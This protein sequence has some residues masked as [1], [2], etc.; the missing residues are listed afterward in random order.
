[1]LWAEA[2]DPVAAR[3]ARGAREAQ[4][5]GQLVRAYLLYQA[6]A[7]RDP[8][9]STYRANCDALAPAA[10]LLTKADIQNADVSAEIKA[11][12][13]EPVGGEPPVEL[14]SLSVW[15]HDESLQPLPHLLAKTE[16]PASFDIR[17]DEKSLFQQ[18]AATYGIRPIFDPQLDVRNDIRFQ[19][20]KAEFRTVMEALTA[21]THTFIFPISQH[22]FFVARDTELKRNELEPNI[23]LTFPL[24]NAL[25]QKD[26]LE[27]A[28]AVR[29]VLNLRAV[30]WDSANRTVM[31][32][33][34]YTRARVARSLLD[35]LLLPKPQVSFEVQFLTFD[36]D[37]SYH[38]GLA[39]QTSF[40]LG[41]F[42]HIG[43]FQTIPAMFSTAMNFATFGGGA[44]LFGVALTNATVFA[45]Y[46]KSVSNNVFDATVVVAD[47][48]TAN[49]H[50]GDKWPIP[51]TLYTGFQQS[52]NSIYNPIGQVTL[53][54]LGIIL[55]M[56]PHVDGSG[57]I[58][59][60]LEASYKALGTQTI[61]TVPSILQRE[62]KGSVNMR[63]GEWAVIAGMDLNMQNVSRNGLYGITQIPGLNQFLSENTRE[64]QI[65]N[66][67]I[68]IKPTITR[69]P[70]SPWISP[71]YL[72]GPARGERVL[73]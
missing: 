27:A 36:S 46:S 67:L 70:M 37:R 3:L 35:A 26:L 29:S 30:G 55:K 2:A 11:A 10:K 15:Q 68:V 28:N 72:L 69:L 4:K 22:D 12:E 38:Y 66:T 65:S 43:G 41:Y 63:E 58:S 48:Q 32:R 17:G 47:G 14:A 57:G 49:F 20:E 59:L 19:I 9:N 1:M 33:D 25:E 16:Q 39:M 56:T 23:L 45:T 7:A 13:V 44:T 64:T 31:I 6:A 54:D 34:R 52:S 51:Q 61:N 18:V 42:G 21:V 60:D 50:V 24:P 53:E 5:S 40:T 62:F 8:H 71:Q 73:L